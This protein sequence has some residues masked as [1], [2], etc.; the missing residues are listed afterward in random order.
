MY[1]LIWKGVTK[2]MGQS[3][4]PFRGNPAVEAEVSNHASLQSM[5]PVVLQ[6]CSLLPS[7]MNLVDSYLVDWYLVDWNHVDCKL[8]II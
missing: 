5:Y 3:A 6:S 4:G 1:T 8:G 2:L 7:Y